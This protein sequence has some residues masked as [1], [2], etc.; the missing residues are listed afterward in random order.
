VTIENP[1]VL[2]PSL[3]TSLMVDAI[4]DC[5]NLKVLVVGS[6][7]GAIPV[8]CALSGGIVT[9]IDINP[10]AV[11]CTLRHALSTGVKIS[12]RVTDF[13]QLDDDVDEWDLVVSNPP[14]QPSDDLPTCPDWLALAHYGGRYGLEFLHGLF[15][16]ASKTLKPGGRLVCS[17]IDFLRD[18]HWTGY[19]V[20]LGLQWSLIRAG[21]KTKGPFTMREM[22]R[23]P[24]GFAPSS[25]PKDDYTIRV[26]A[27][28]RQ[29][30][31]PRM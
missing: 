6:G 7:A 15:R 3:S 2:A 14:Q 23:N 12:A 25:L 19:A 8:S 30:D 26:F 22:G 31:L 11:E 29:H 1:F 18:E 28:A 24:A 17:I 20:S 9:A 13:W 10:V 4:G 16:Y 5:T 21:R 27:F